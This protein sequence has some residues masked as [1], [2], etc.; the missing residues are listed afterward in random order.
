MGTIILLRGDEND[1]QYYSYLYC[2]ISDY[3]DFVLYPQIIV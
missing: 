1:G 3:L 2:G